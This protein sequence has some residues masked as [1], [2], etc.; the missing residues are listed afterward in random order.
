MT[1]STYQVHE[2]IGKL[3]RAGYPGP[4]RVKVP[5]YAVASLLREMGTTTDI[6]VVDAD[7]EDK[8]VC[9]GKRGKGR[10]KCR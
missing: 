9:G 2:A 10:R 6:F 3:R 5:G 4:Y 1:V 8:S 7:A